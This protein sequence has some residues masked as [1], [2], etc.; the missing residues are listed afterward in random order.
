[1]PL[2]H[3]YAQLVVAGDLEKMVGPSSRSLSGF[4]RHFTDPSS[5]LFV[6][7]DDKG[8]WIVSWLTP[9]MSGGSW[10]L[11]LRPDTRGVGRRQ[12]LAV[13]ME[14]INL[15]LTLWPVLVNTTT[16]PTV[17]AKTQRLGY[18]YLGCVPYLFGGEDCYVLYIT[19]PMF[20]P[21]YERW[22]QY[23]GRRKNRRSA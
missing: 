2:L 20:A 7:T 15:G 16:Q 6:G 3:W 23:Y 9:L 14:S 21:L 4:M 12:A 13:I 22:S 11:W 1:V 10:G 19:R 17:V 8:W 5:L 18:A